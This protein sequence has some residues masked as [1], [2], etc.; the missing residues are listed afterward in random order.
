MQ[1]IERLRAEVEALK[2]VLSVLIDALPAKQTIALRVEATCQA[3]EGKL[4][5][6]KMTDAQLAA[7]HDVARLVAPNTVDPPA[8]RD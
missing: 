1:E 4:L 3:Y 5:W 8:L 2:L 6:S 7:I